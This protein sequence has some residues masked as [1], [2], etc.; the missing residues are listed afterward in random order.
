MA[1]GREIDYIMRVSRGGF[2]GGLSLTAAVWKDDDRRSGSEVR[3][4]VKSMR[5][6]QW[7]KN[8]I[9]FAALIFARELFHAPSFLRAAGG[10]VVFC[11]L[12]GAVYLLNDCADLRQDR[13]H[14]IKRH[15]PL[16]SGRLRMSRALWTMGMLTVGCLVAARFLGRGFFW[17]CAGYFFLQVAY[18]F[19]LKR[20]VIVDAL[21]VA[22]GFV[23]RVLAGA[24][25]ISVEISPWLVICTALLAVFL[26]LCKRRHE[27][28]LVGERA[29]H[30][31]AVLAEYSPYLLD[32]MIGVVTACT[33]M[34]YVLYTIAPETVAK[35]G[36]RWMILTAPFV[37][38]GILR[39][40]YLVHR[41]GKGGRPEAVL[42]TDP[43]LLVDVALWAATGAAIVY[44]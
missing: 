28:V 33:V 40:L 20:V 19:G 43:A 31:R 18:S 38:Y 29:D 6:E 7:S 14:P 21:A 4:L 34:A 30:H 10:C 12:S 25:V 26:A 5:V 3:M 2:A 11:L 1:S 8:L 9:L 41:K 15:R 24:V 17:I 27:L 42:L 36:T 35:F 16:A 32:Q 39:Y 37:L 13:R 23:L 22:A 44:W